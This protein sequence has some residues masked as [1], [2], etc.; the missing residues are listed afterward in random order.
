MSD[1]LDQANRVLQ[2]RRAAE[3]LEVYVSRALETEITAYQGSVE[4]LTSATSS[5]FGVRVLRDGPGGARVG[6][7]WAGTLDDYSVR[8][9]LREARDNVRFASPDEFVGFASPDGVES[10]NLSLRDEAVQAKRLEEK[11]SLAIE[12]ERKARVGDTRIRQ[13]NSATYADYDIESAVVSSLGIRASHTRS[14]AHLSVQVIASDG[15]DDQ[16]GWGLSARRS[17][18]DLD[19]S[20]AADDAITRATRMLGALKPSSMRCSVVFGARSASTLLSVIAG[21]LSGDAVVRGRSF[22]VDRVGEKVAS[23]LLTLLDDPT[24]Q[25]HFSASSFDAEGLACRRNVL[26]DKGE[27]KGFVYDSNAARRAS[28]LSTGSALRAGVGGSPF[29]G[30]RAVQ[31]SPGEQ[32]LEA[33]LRDVNEGVYVESLMGV[34]SGVNSVSGDFSVGVTGFMIRGGQLAEPIREVTVA[35]TLQRMLLDLSHVGSEVEWLPGV[36]T[37][38]VLAISSLAV[39]GS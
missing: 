1:L 17:P 13:V 30:C 11:I 37:G 29:A 35:S 3:H 21:A 34:H 19:S 36:A 7:A 27:L 9:A 23:P 10:V 26:I 4:K 28:T 33:I 14:G 38:H 15:T 5:G 12:L 18:N 8:E 2:D 20:E 39:S 16:T 6:T 32:S 25:H 24:D 31:L 22:F